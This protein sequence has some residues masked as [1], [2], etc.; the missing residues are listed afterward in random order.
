MLLHQQTLD[1]TTIEQPSMRFTKNVMEAIENTSIT[2][3]T[4][5]YI[6]LRLVK[7]IAAFFI[8]TIISLLGYTVSQLDFSTVSIMPVKNM[9]SNIPEGATD[10]IKNIMIPVNI[11]AAIIL[12]DEMRSKKIRMKET[13]S[14]ML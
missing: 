13:N 8:L 6:N 5:K 9:F 10:L 2:P 4:R 1:V 7:G 12:A 3:A 11:I 14:Q